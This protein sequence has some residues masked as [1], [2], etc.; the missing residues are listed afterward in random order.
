MAALST[1]IADRY[2]SAYLINLTNA[3]APAATTVNG[4]FQTT[5]IADAEAA[6]EIYV[7]VT[8]DQ[9]DA[10]HVSLGCD[11]VIAKLTQYG[12]KSREEGR[13]LWDN[14]VMGLK[15]LRKKG[16]PVTTARNVPTV[17]DSA[18]KPYF[19]TQKLAD[20]GPAGEQ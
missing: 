12:G 18:S 15:A 7:G 13:E 9:D 3:G 14:F 19:D 20:Y 11:G 1:E 10:R 5:A 4:T 6:F 17:E 16:K 2:P 8:F